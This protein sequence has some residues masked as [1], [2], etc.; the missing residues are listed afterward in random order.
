MVFPVGVDGRIET[1]VERFQ[2][3]VMPLVRQE[4]TR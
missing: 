3:E 2:L 1:T 4:L